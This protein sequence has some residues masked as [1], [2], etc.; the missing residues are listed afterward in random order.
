MG[1]R[2]SSMLS[3]EHAP[4][5]K[6]V[7]SRSPVLDHL[8]TATV[9]TGAA[10]LAACSCSQPL[11][12]SGPAVG[13]LL[14]RSQRALRFRA[15]SRT[16]GAPSR[17]GVVLHR[18]REGKGLAG[19]AARQPLSATTYASVIGAAPGP[20][21]LD[22]V[23]PYLAELNSVHTVGVV[24]TFPRHGAPIAAAGG[25]CEPCCSAICRPD[26]WRSRSR[27]RCADRAAVLHRL[28]IADLAR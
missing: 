22:L 25:L 11:R 14:S 2:R 12:E 3:P 6:R 26:P 5:G 8:L 23:R 7:K 10:T 28:G 24:T 20:P 4:T 1:N 16:R 18:D 21:G 19:A 17:S 27:V 15:R 9:A 13:Q